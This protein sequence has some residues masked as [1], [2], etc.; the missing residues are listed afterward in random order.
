MIR[1]SSLQLAEKCDLA[2]VLG[3]RFPVTN[4]NIERGITVETM[5]YEALQ[6]GA[7]PLDPEAADCVRWIRAHIEVLEVQTLVKLWDLDTNTV[8]TEGT[9]DI[10]G[11]DSWSPDTLVIVDLKKREQLIAGRL[12]HIDDNLQLHAYAIAQVLHRA[13][14]SYRTCFLTFG[15]G[16]AE[17]IWSRAYTCAE[18]LPILKRIR[19][20]CARESQRGDNEPLGKAGPHCTDCYSRVHCRHWALPA[21]QGPSVLEP[22][23]RPGGITVENAGQGLLAIKALREIA[24]RAEAQLQAFRELQGPGSV[25]VGE[26][27]WEPIEVSGRPTADVASLRRAGLSEYIKEGRPYKQWRLVRTAKSG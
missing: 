19:V 20:I 9:P 14:K 17:A 26:K 18:W 6:T 16:K 21:H 5:V 10:V 7:G 22:F 27:T 23:T 8:T 11:I 25:I 1:P 12:A 4:A 13:M 15:D 2:A 3:A 24:D